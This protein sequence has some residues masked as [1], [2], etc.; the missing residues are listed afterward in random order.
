MSVDNKKGLSPVIATVLLVSIVLILAAII[1]LW[2]K[3]FVSEQ[4]QKNG[5]PVADACG[6]VVFDVE[7]ENLGAALSLQLVN[8]GNVPIAAI[9][10]EFVSG[11]NSALQQFNMTADV[12]GSSSVQAIPTQSATKIIIY[13]MVLGTV[14]GKKLNKAVTC[15]DKGKEIIL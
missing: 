10:V 4:I 15:M 7:Y 12:L 9:D 8:K 3:G 13:P 2:M 14:V 6:N 1:F 11:G 5:N